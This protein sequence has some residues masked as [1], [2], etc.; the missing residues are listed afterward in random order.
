[1][2]GRGTLGKDR[3]TLGELWHTFWEVRGTLG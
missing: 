3:E 2:M 1:M